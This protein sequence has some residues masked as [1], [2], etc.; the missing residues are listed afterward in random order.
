[1]HIMAGRFDLALKLAGRWA[2][3]SR[4]I[5]NMGRSLIHAVAAKGGVN[6]DRRAPPRHSFCVPRDR[7]QIKPLN[8]CVLAYSAVQI[9][10]K[11]F[12]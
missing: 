6:R 1:M 7:T 10:Q 3:L 4:A 9:G 11:R 12:T 8:V 5:D 2:Y